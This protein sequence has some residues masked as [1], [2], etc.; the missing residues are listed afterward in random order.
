M[1]K[2]AWQIAQT[3]FTEIKQVI[4]ELLQ[5]KTQQLTLIE[6]SDFYVF[7]Y[8]DPPAV[9]ERKSEPRRA[10]ICVLGALIGVIISIIVILIRHYVI[11]KKI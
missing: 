2:F 10:I 6:A 3:S 4:A 7:E 9:M 11:N 8:I 5:Q 1:P